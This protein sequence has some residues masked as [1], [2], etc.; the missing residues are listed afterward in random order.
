MINYKSYAVSSKPGVHLQERS[1][2]PPAG[3]NGT[4]FFQNIWLSE[5]NVLEKDTKVPCC[6]RRIAFSSGQTPGLN[7]DRVSPVNYTSY[8]VS[9]REENIVSGRAGD[10]ILFHKNLH[11][12]QIFVKKIQKY[13]AAAGESRFHRVKRPV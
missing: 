8:A 10:S 9:F 5:P 4:F 11:I 12:V 6:R 2:S 13:H 1:D 7:A 3:R